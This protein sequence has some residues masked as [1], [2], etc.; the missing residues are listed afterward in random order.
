LLKIYAKLKQLS[1]RAAAGA[2]TDDE[3]GSPLMGVLLAEDRTQWWAAERDGTCCF[4][5][6][7][8]LDDASAT[9]FWR[10]CGGWLE[11][12]GPCASRLGMHLIADARE[13]QPSSGD[14]VWVTRATRVLAVG[15]RRQE[16]RA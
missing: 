13:A 9:V 8:S 15:L 12:H 5:C 2:R 3:A 1:S 11:L 4:R 10:G 7:E 16:Q 14:R 6:G